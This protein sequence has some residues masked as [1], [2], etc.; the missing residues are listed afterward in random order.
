VRMDREIRALKDLVRATCHSADVCAAILQS[1]REPYQI[2]SVEQVR[3]DRRLILVDLVRCLLLRGVPV[4]EVRSLMTEVLGPVDP[5]ADEEV[6]R[7]DLAIAERKLELALRNALADAQI[8]QAT[9]ELLSF[10]YLRLQLR[11]SERDEMPY[12]ALAFASAP[13]DGAP[14]VLH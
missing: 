4:P 10:H 1:P 9:L 7:L 8:S 13:V 6:L 3:E 14:R 12:A 11:L 5:E 2:L